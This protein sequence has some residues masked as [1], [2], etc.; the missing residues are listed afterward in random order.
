MVSTTTLTSDNCTP[1]NRWFPKVTS[2]ADTDICPITNIKYFKILV[3]SP[4]WNT[5]DL[6]I[7]KLN[8]DEKKR[9]KNDAI[10]I[11]SVCW[12]PIRN[13]IKLKAEISTINE[14]ADDRINF[15]KVLYIFIE[16]IIGL[17]WEDSFSL[18]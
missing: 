7:I 12:F 17:K 11:V 8:R 9:D 10:K 14:L 16:S 18:I 1:G 4:F 13:T 2:R 5:N 6:F 3:L 15:K